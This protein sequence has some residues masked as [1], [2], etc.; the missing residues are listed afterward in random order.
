MSVFTR[1][2]CC[3]LLIGFSALACADEPW[4]ADPKRVE[5]RM[6]NSGGFNYRE[7]DV[8]EFVLPDPLQTASGEAVTAEDWPQR[9]EQLLQTFRD[10]IYGQRPETA[11][12]VRF[13]VVDERPGVFD[14]AADAW[15][16]RITV[17][18]GD[19][20]YSFSLLVFA[21]RSVFDPREAQ[22]ETDVKRP[23]IV[24]LNNREF[25]TLESA[26]NEPSDFWPV[27][28][29]CKQGFVAAAVSTH[30]IDP[31][32][33][34][35]FENGIR[36]FLAKASGETPDDHAWAALS[37][38]GWGVSRAVD[39]LL[40]LPS[41]DPEK[42]AVVGHSR[43]GKAAL[44]AAA[45][46]PRIAIAYSNNSGCGGAA[47]SR[48]Q[49]GETVARIT[50]AFPHWFCGQFASYADREQELPVDQHELIALI[51]PRAVYVAS[52]TD[53]LWADPRGEY[54]SLLHAAPV[55]RLLDQQAIDQAEMP[56]AD[57][58]RY[59]GRTGY[60]IRTGGHGLTPSDW[61]NFMQFVKQLKD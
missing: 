2:V 19:G 32:K 3:C 37:A 7:A 33:A 1:L 23:A 16:V 61:Q 20:E 28:E 38:W 49:F 58:P 30:E 44:W 54:L 21:P 27:R 36:G 57:K 35:Q 9:R 51:A 5:E 26:I 56:A 53:D 45:E 31:D 52:A 4:Q 15:Q 41:V 48:R 50:S 46:D 10:H 43:G 55:F 22:A 18:A 13:L 17:S 34:G 12:R 60:H 6:K 39:Y 59:V 14:G 11:Y 29:I 47:L 42:I 25:P 24:H 8:P 40:T